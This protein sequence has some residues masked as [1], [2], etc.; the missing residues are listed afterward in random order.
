MNG[1]TQPVRPWYGIVVVPP[2]EVV[3][4]VRSLQAHVD[5]S[6]S[7]PVPHITLKLP[8]QVRTRLA[9]VRARVGEVVAATPPITVT[10]RGVGGFPGPYTPAVYAT[11]QPN[12]RLHSLHSRLVRALIG[13]ADNV[14]PYT[15]ELELKHYVPHI[16]LASDLSRAE[17]RRVMN[18]LRGY[19]LE[20]RFQIEEVELSRRG[21]RRR[22]SR[23]EVLPLGTA[24]A[25]ARLRRGGRE[26]AREAGA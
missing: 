12:R 20:G 9:D 17:Y 15:E 3:A 13:V 18:R 26:R 8:F 4:L 2:P 7:D 25:G 19:Q 23:V 1:A 10:L 14:L 22:W 16:T 6:R 21:V 11:V 24:V 5:A